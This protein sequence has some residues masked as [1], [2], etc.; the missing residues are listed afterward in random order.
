[1]GFPTRACMELTSDEAMKQ[2][3]RL[4]RDVSLSMSWRMESLPGERRYNCQ[5][6]HRRDI[7]LMLQIYSSAGK[8]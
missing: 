1:M 4:V 8:L 5:G 6:P 2:S 3:L 7:T